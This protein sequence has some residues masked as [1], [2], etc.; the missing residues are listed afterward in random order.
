VSLSAAD[1]SS[2]AAAF[3]E[4][5]AAVAA[6]ELERAAAL[7]YAELDALRSLLREQP[8]VFGEA[9]ELVADLRCAGT[10]ANAD[11]ECL[12]LY[13]ES[14]LARLATPLARSY[15]VAA[16]ALKAAA[17]AWRLHG[18]SASVEALRWA[19]DCEAEFP[20]RMARESLALISARH[21]DYVGALAV[22][23]AIS[24]E[25]GPF[26]DFPA[27]LLF[28]A[29]RFAEAAA[30]WQTVPFPFRDA[31]LL[32]CAWAL[33][34]G[35]Q[36]AAALKACAPLLRKNL[37][38]LSDEVKACATLLA[39]MIAGE[40]VAMPPSFDPEWGLIA[41]PET[42]E[43]NLAVF[44][45]VRPLPSAALA[46]ELER[47]AHGETLALARLYRIEAAARKGS[48]EHH[49]RALMLPRLRSALAI[50]DRE[51]SDMAERDA[52]LS[53]LFYGTLGR[54]PDENLTLA[55]RILGNV[56]RGET[57]LSSAPFIVSTAVGVLLQSDPPRALALARHWFARFERDGALENGVAYA[58]ARAENANGDAAAAIVA[59]T[60]AIELC[61]P[62]DYGFDRKTFGWRNQLAGLARTA[63]SPDEELE[64]ALDAEREQWA[65]EWTG[66]LAKRSRTRLAVPLL[67]P[68]L[69]PDQQFCDVPLSVM[70]RV[71]EA[72]GRGFMASRVNARPSHREIF[73]ACRPHAAE[74]KLTGSFGNGIEVD[75]LETAD[76]PAT[77]KA[78]ASADE[79]VPL[80]GDRLHCW[81]D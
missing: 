26:F 64:R 57:A 81:W 31:A 17:V 29:G 37:V 76:T 27:G 74:T 67:K 47:L 61:D 49:E 23:G 63:G 48:G 56:E 41:R 80:D 20:A 33:H 35:G 72:I 24:A 18:D 79:L 66:W 1:L 14:T 71:G 55:E 10:F 51:G 69:A 58:L 3:V 43:V 34:R 16:A 12:A 40:A 22:L 70:E 8:V 38:T 75:T 54:L 9:I 30:L 60:R 42:H 6:R 77:R 59:L 32:N 11:A 45:S 78:F 46:A 65:E 73:V 5:R 7:A 19:L 21:E 4:I 44:F 53:E 25:D 28:G 68:Y 50:V 36:D 52:V 39:R 62:E 2:L 15:S 13:R